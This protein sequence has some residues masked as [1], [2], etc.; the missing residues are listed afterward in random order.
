MEQAVHGAGQLQQLRAGHRFVVKHPQGRHPHPAHHFIHFVG[1]IRSICPICPAGHATCLFPLEMA[2]WPPITNNPTGCVQYDYF[3]FFLGTDMDLVGVRFP[4][5][6]PR[7]VQQNLLLAVKGTYATHCD[8]DPVHA[9]F[10]STY[11]QATLK[12]GPYHSSY[13]VPL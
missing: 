8:P 11:T 2:C 3:H 5:N 12:G 9:T 13:V 10:N 7:H 1:P 6:T 4:P